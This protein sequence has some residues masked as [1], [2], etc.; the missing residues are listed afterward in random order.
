MTQ[1]LY[2]FWLFVRLKTF[3]LRQSYGFYI[4]DFLLVMVVKSFIQMMVISTLTSNAAYFE[5]I[6]LKWFFSEKKRNAKVPLV[7]R[8]YFTF[9]IVCQFILKHETAETWRLIVSRKGMRT[10]KHGRERTSL[11]YVAVAQSLHELVV[12]LILLPVSDRIKAA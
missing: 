11:T 9:S 7:P 4:W 8:D 5:E 1:I 10:K 2:V 6:N 12:A 3:S